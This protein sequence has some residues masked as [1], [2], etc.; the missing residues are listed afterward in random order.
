[1][2]II[3][4]ELSEVRA[5]CENQVPGSKVVAAVK[6]LVRIEI[7]RTKFKKLACCF[8]FPNDYPNS[9]ILFELKSKTLSDKL[10][11]G[12]TRVTEQE[13]KKHLGRPQILFATK[14]ITK[15]IEDN[16]LC[17]CA[18]EISRVKKLLG[19]D[20]VIK[21]SQKNSTVNMTINK[22]R[23]FLKCKVVIPDIYPEERV[24]ITL[25]D[26]NFPRVFKAWF[27]ENAKELARRCVEAPLKPKPNAPPFVHKPS[28]EVAVSFLVA[29]VQRYPLEACQVCHKTLFPPDPD[30]S[31]H[32][33][34]AAAHVERVYCG[35]AY[36][37][38]CL[39]LYLKTPPFDGGKKCPGCGKRIYHEKWKVTPELAEARW[40]SEQAKARELG[41]VVEFAR[42]LKLM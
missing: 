29:S 15:F 17:C 28:L 6:D 8:M 31:I 4:D 13:C 20:D 10:L 9:P 34:K 39:I 27:V 19:P 14:F 5:V 42:D 37:H 21:L 33:E 22:E 35:H 3:Q 2:G 40:A 32:N 11:D 7:E 26:C 12:L 23:Y 1:M 41:D 16:P 25:V 38:D 30:Q 36:H 24:D 18:E